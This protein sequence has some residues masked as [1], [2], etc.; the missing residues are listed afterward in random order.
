MTQ[1]L[2]FEERPGGLWCQ[3]AGIP[4]HYLNGVTFQEVVKCFGEVRK[5]D[6][7][8]GEGGKLFFARVLVEVHDLACIPETIVTKIGGRHFIIRVNAE[9]QNPPKH[10]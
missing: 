9:L 4:L 6:M 7:G 10:S 8:L 3:L 1:H 2:S 5:V